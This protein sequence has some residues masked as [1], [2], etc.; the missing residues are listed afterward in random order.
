MHPAFDSQQFQ[1]YVDSKDSEGLAQ[2]VRIIDNLNKAIA[3]DEA[4][5]PGF[6]VGHSYVVDNTTDADQSWLES[7]VEDELIPLVEEY[8]FDSPGKITEW[9]DKLRGALHG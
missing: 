4:L 1:D 8:W 2:L 9:A 5:G 3:Q 6:E 7:V